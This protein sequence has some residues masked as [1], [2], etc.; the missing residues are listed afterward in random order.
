MSNAAR[1]LEGTMGVNRPG[2]VYGLDYPVP[3]S[4]LTATFLDGIVRIAAAGAA[5]FREFVI[6]GTTKLFTASKDTYVYCDPNGSLQYV[7][8]AL[9]AAKPLQSTIGATSEWLFKVITDGSNITT[10]Q[11]LRRFAGVKVRVFAGIV[12]SF[13]TAQQ[14]PIYL[15]PGF[16]GRVLALDGVV[17][18]VLAGTDAGTVTPAIGKNGATPVAITGAVLSFPLSTIAGVRR[19]E[20]P[21][22]ANQFGASDAIV[23]TSAK[24]TAGGVVQCTVVCEEQ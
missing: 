4:G 19:C 15:F 10:V 24:T 14:G 7:E 20:V 2:V 16:K 11:D 17:Q 3:A 9:G 5:G 22:G 21:T 18:T 13:V 6:Q 1:A 23:L 8:L 12:A